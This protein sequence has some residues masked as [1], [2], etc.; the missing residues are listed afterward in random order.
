M[1]NF[2]EESQDVLEF[3][4]SRDIEK[5]YKIHFIIDQNNFFFFGRTTLVDASIETIPMPK[6]S[7]K[8]NN[9]IG[10]NNVEVFIYLY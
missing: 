4:P 5:Y 8:S 7:E 9:T 6:T 3:L 10:M 2:T 1:D